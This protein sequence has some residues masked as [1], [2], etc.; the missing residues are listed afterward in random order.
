MHQVNLQKPILTRTPNRLLAALDVV[1]RASVQFGAD[2]VE[3]VDM[4]G[5]LSIATA[6]ILLRPRRFRLTSAIYQLYR[7]GWQAVPIMALITFLIGG[8][9]RHARTLHVHPVRGR[10]HPGDLLWNL[11]V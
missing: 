4:L 6:H 5:D 8:V 11:L 3:F 7:V 1:G 10:G 9:L 2:F